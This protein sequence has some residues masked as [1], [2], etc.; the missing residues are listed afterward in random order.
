[1]ANQQ[2]RG[3]LEVIAACS[4]E[5]RSANAIADLLGDRTAQATKA[6]ADRLV[7]D[8]DLSRVPHPTRANAWRYEA[9]QQGLDRLASEPVLLE[10]NT[11]LVLIRDKLDPSA[12]SVIAAFVQI[13]PPLWIFRLHGRYRLA[14]AYRDSSSA[15]TLEQGINQADGSAS[16]ASVVRADQVR[17]PVQF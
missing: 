10:P 16:A 3:Q 15:D 4:V 9:T 11:Y 17:L 8:G 7:T 6:L 13:H 2:H 1:M 12:A 5:P 14:V